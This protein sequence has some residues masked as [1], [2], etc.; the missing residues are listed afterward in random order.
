MRGR[1]GEKWSV[2]MGAGFVG[3]VMAAVIANTRD[4]DGKFSKFVIVCQRPSTRSYWKIP[5]LNRGLSPVKSED[6]EVD[7]LID[8][9]VTREK[10]LSSYL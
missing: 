7:V 4:K 9:C 10:T 8:Q 2:V 5:M 1:K 6:P 3:A